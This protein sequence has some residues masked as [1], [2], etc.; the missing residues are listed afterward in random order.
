[1]IHPCLRALRHVYQRGLVDDFELVEM[2]APGSSFA[3]AP[4]AT[5]TR[6]LDETDSFIAIPLE[7][8][9]SQPSFL[10]AGTLACI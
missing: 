10:F 6:T 4:F 1:V 5:W 2:D 3:F 8:D 7:Q 9:G